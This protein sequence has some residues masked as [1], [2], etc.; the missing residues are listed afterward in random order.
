METYK[1]C[2]LKELPP[3]SRK[4]INVGR[5]S[6]GVFNVKGK[7]VAV[8]NSCPHQGAPLCEGKVDGMTILND[9]WELEYVREDEILR[10]P[11]HAW[12]F[13]LYNGK[14]IFNP[15]RCHT[16]SYLVTVENELNYVDKEP[17]ETYD[18][19]IEEEVIYVHV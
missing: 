7:L 17:V 2:N 9:K 19:S 13:D 6:I 8:K 12:E 5:K 14:S 1:V 10:C 4:I 11:W 16:K 15:S 3:G 18:V